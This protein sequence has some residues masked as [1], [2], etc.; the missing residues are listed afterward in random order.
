M[1]AFKDRFDAA[2]VDTIAGDLA[3]VAGRRFS[4]Q[5]FRDGCVGLEALELSGRV[6]RIAD[7]MRA[8]LGAMPTREVMAAII[9]AWP[10]ARE[11]EQDP[12]GASFGLWPYGELIGRHGLDDVEASFTAMIELTQRF[13]SEFAVRPFLAQDC[14]GMLARMEALVTHPNPHVRRWVSEG[15]RTRLPWGKRVPALA[16]AQARRIALLER[17]RHDGERY[18][19]RSVANHLGDILKDDLAAG[20]TVLRRWLAEDHEGLTWI[21]RHAARAQLKAGHAEVLALFGH[22]TRST[23]LADFTV[24]PPRVRIGEAVTLQAEMTHGG[25]RAASLRI[26]YALIRPSARGKP[27]RKVFRWADRNLQPGE[28]VVLETRYTFA[29][30]SIRAVAPGVHGFELIVNGEVLASRP[31]HVVA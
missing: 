21:A 22:D 15:T 7:A 16:R 14:D 6:V 20:I 19:Q 2:L 8:G 5:R 10:P 24:S 23:E 26:D 3:R 31:V 27:S 11:T 18:V 9:A 28:A 29:P 1:A 13:T 17:L 30:R 12:S 25:A 4:A